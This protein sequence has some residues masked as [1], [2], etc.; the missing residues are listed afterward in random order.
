MR[1]ATASQ[2]RELDRITIQERGVP[3]TDLME[4][5]AAALARAALE[6]AGGAPGRAVCFCGPGNNGGDGVACAR[7]L[8]EA[9]LEVRCVLVGRREKLTPDTRAMEARL[10]AAGGAL[11]P[12]A[13]DDAEFAAWCLEADVMVDAIFGIGLKRPLE[14]IFAEDYEIGQHSGK[15]LSLILFVKAGE[16][17]S[18]C[19]AV[20]SLLDGEG[21][22]GQIGPHGPVQRFSGD[23]ALDPRHNVGKLNG[24]VGT[25][26]H[27]YAAFHE[28]FP[29]VAGGRQFCSG[30]LLDDSDIVIQKDALGVHMEI[31][32]ADPLQLIR[33]GDLAVDDPVAVI[34]PGMLF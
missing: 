8:R 31:E 9:G 14:G 22:L 34:G 15:N 11:E 21:F 26:A 19:K 17:G 27:G 33:S 30:P 2:M 25:V 5:A 28:G 4:R 20:Q 32:T 18:F 16:C 13:P 6:L 23:G 3:S 7:L 1:I 24:A 12:F 10:A 29:A